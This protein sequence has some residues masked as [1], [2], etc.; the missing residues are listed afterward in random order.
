MAIFGVPT[1]RVRI[2]VQT[3]LFLLWAILVYSTHY[4]MQSWIATH[5]PVSLFLRIDPLVATVIMGGMRVGVTI[6]LL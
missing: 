2:V 6:L 4:P 3:S 5:I 1:R